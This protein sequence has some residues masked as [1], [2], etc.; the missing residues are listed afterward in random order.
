MFSLD[1]ADGTLDYEPL[2]ENSVKEVAALNNQTVDETIYE[3]FM[4]NSGRGYVH[5]PLFNYSNC[6][7][8]HVYKLLRHPATMASL[9]DAGAHC[10]LICDASNPTFLLSYWTRDRRLG[11]RFGV[12]EVV[13]MLTQRP[14][15]VF[16]FSDRG[17]IAPGMKADINL[18]KYD[19]L[20]LCAPFISYDLPAGGKRLLQ[21]ANGYRFTIVNGVVTFENG[22]PTGELPGTLI[23]RRVK[24]PAAGAKV[25]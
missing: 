23:R 16:G 21:K 24:A 14:A 22:S 25:A 3:L 10:A 8:N 13:T 19:E 2:P 6:N 18:I 1:A 5:A 17:L 4:Q 15:E 12:E 11:P 7:L 20:Q 9:S